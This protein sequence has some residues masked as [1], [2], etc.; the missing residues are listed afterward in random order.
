[1]IIEKKG[2]L[3]RE[4]NCILAHQVNCRGVMGAGVAKQIRDKILT[5]EDFQRYRDVCKI[6]PSDELLGQVLLS[7]HGKKPVANLFAEDKP[8]GDKV[9][10]D[11]RALYLCLIR[12]RNYAEKCNPVAEIAV[13]KYLGCGLAG[14]D[15]GIVYKM[16]Q[17]LFKNHPVTV[18]I[19][20]LRK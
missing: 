4:E 3:L 16:I 1:M 14:G 10:T 2:D 6:T 17:K 15:W 20:E 7:L 11:Y 5:K 19:V 13:P 18:R 8:T 9:D 12:L